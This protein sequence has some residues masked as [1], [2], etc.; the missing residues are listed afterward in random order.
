MALSKRAGRQLSL[1]KSSDTFVKFTCIHFTDHRGFRAIIL[2]AFLRQERT[3]AETAGIETAPPVQVFLSCFDSQNNE[4][5]M[6]RNRK[7]LHKS[8]LLS[9]KKKAKHKP[10]VKQQKLPLSKR[11][12]QKMKEPGRKTVIQHPPPNQAKSSIPKKADLKTSTKEF[13]T[14]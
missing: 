14:S 2:I 3:M 13:A 12:R 1:V 9:R 4:G 10:K 5:I 6:F 8:N 11:K 7:R